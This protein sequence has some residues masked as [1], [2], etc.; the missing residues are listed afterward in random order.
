MKKKPHCA[1]SSIK[2]RLWMHKLHTCVHYVGL[3]FCCMCYCALPMVLQ[4]ELLRHTCPH[5][6]T[7]ATIF[8]AFQ[9][10]ITV[11]LLLSLLG[12]AL[13]DFI[14]YLFFCSPRCCANR[15]TSCVAQI[16]TSG[17]PVSLVTYT[18]ARAVA[19]ESH[20]SR[21]NPHMHNADKGATDANDTYG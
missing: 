10:G 20:L 17:L 21:R 6:D 14:I 13:Q 18:W 4:A 11:E 19:L 8:I 1:V 12:S 5:D 9:P 15:N 16:E 3:L 7:A 2:N